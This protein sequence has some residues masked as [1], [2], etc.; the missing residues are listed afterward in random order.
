MENKLNFA[1][2]IDA[3]NASSK[4]INDIIFMMCRKLG[5]LFIRR[6]YG[7]FTSQNLATWK[8]ICSQH[9]IQPIQQF[10]NT[11]GKNATDSA[12]IIDAMDILYQKKNEL[13][14][15]FIL[16]SS[17]SDFTKLASR[18][19][20]NNLKVIG[21]G[22]KDTANS[23][24]DACNEFYF[25]ENLE[26]DIAEQKI[27]QR[28][29]EITQSILENALQ[30]IKNELHVELSKTLHNELNALSFTKF[31]VV[32]EI[33]KDLDNINKQLKD[34]VDSLINNNI[35]NNT[36][37][38]NSKI[39]DNIKNIRSYIFEFCNSDKRKGK[40]VNLGEFKKY[41]TEKITDFSHSKYGC[42]NFSMFIEKYFGDLIIFY[43]RATKFKLN[44]YE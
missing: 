23:F 26:K 17:D 24:I 28:E 6:I 13:N 29:T 37:E 20:E 43:D 30:K 34:Y 38:E 22:R 16:V 2:L 19:R 31:D 15:G 10:R 36:K 1:L 5:H 8:E 9:N 14:G 39:E 27:L 44:K 21:I 35:D 32:N 12:L 41:I 33:N 25:V 18:I 11:I 4:K 40:F 7:D 3:D 42:K